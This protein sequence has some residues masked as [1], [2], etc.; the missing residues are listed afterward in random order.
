MIGQNLLM[1]LAA[2]RAS[3][4][5]SFLTMLGIIIG[6]SSVVTVLATGEGVKREITKQV[7]SFGV[8]LIQVNPGRLFSSNEEGEAT[9][10]NFA[11]ALGASTLNEN[12][13]ESIR[14]IPEVATAAP[15]TLISGIPS[16]EGKTADSALI[17]AS[18][19]ELQIILAANQKLERGRFL[20]DA[21]SNETVLGAKVAETLFGANQDILGKAITVRGRQLTVVGVMQAPPSTALTLGPDIGNVV[22][23]PFGVGK[24]MNNGVVNIIEID[25]KAA[26][27][28]KVA[29]AKTKIWQQLLSN[30]GGEEDFTVS[31]P[32][33]QLAL[34]D[35]ILNVMTSFVAAI[36]AISLIVGGVGVMNIMLVAVTERTREIGVRKAIGATNRQIL[37]QFLIEAIVISLL[38]GL[39]GVGLAL[40]YGRVIKAAADLTPVFTAEAFMVAVIV[41]TVVGVIFGLAPAI[42]A[43]R[44][45]P[46]EALRYE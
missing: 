35:Q 20:A 28:E 11:G 41:S 26:D 45:S 2:L 10:F 36:A 44:K 16:G 29:V 22:Y 23:I 15:A 19:P 8:D 6:V 32:D 27:P 3:K 33:E 25:V 31:T 12:D 37:G 39:L 5:R 24:E 14:Q 42:K 18:T 43:A 40:V 9:S 21:S 7:A 46:I 13:V 17:L 1:A 30:H 4:L 34:F 38:G